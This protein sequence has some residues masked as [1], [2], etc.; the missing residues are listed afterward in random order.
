MKRLQDPNRRLFNDRIDYSK[1]FG[2]ISLYQT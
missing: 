2:K 1:G